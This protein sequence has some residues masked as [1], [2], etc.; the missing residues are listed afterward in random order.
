MTITHPFLPDDPGV[1][2]MEDGLA[3]LG[4]LLFA[5]GFGTGGMALA[6]FLKVAGM[7]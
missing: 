5:V 2:K 6:V 1:G 4:W 7:I 3:C